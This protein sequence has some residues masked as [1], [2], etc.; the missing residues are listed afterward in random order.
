MLHDREP[1]PRAAHIARPASVDAIEALKDPRAMARWDEAIGIMDAEAKP[2]LIMLFDIDADRSA[3][4]RVLNRVIDEV[5]E[6]LIERLRIAKRGERRGFIVEGDREALLFGAGREIGD[7]LSRELGELDLL[8]DQERPARF[9]A[10][11]RDQI[12]DD[13]LEAHR[14]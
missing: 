4:R 5:D 10:R 2:L 11:E 3:A 13:R 7:H 12:V 8:F 9:K 1:K 14:M 6:H